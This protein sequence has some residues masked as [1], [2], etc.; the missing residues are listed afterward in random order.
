VN[1]YCIYNNEEFLSVFCVTR[2]T[3]KRVVTL[4]KDNPVR[5][6]KNV[7]KQSKHFVPEIHVLATL[8]F[9]GAEGNQNSSKR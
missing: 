1:T 2:S 9:F 3:F 7:D 4:I 5:Q 8:K 6:G